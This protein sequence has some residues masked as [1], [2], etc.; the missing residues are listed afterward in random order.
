V[1]DLQKVVDSDLPI[2][3]I[4]IN[5]KFEITPGLKNINDIKIFKNK[6]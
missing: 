2:Y 4:D 6:L 3:A 1:V 5:S